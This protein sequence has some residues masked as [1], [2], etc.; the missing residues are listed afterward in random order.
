ML[1]RKA[2]YRHA[3]LQAGRNE[4]LFRRR[5]V[6]TAAIAKNP[7]NQQF[8]FI[9]LNHLVSTSVKWTL[10]AK[11]RS[12]RKGAEKFALTILVLG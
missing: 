11:T 1:K 7:P 2:R 10:H 9:V 3:R 12:I 4:T 6:P 8:P 5:I